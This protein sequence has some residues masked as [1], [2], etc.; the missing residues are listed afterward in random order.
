MARPTTLSP[1][2]QA[3]A[4]AVG[5][6]ES[7]KVKLGWGTMVFFRRTRGLVRIA[8][9]E[10]DAVVRLSDKHGLPCPL[11]PYVEAPS[12]ELDLEPLELAGIGLG[13][14]FPLSPSAVDSLRAT[15]TED[16]LVALADASRTPSAN[17]LRAVG[18]LLGL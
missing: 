10:R 13:R 4:R 9:A 3:L 8:K 11:P 14:G 15:Y 6:I 2:W 5:G 17:V 16:E 18:Y 7:L 1:E 12:A